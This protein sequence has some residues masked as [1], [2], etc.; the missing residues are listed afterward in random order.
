M[1]GFLKMDPCQVCGQNPQQFTLTTY[2]PLGSDSLCASCLAR[3]GLMMAKQVLPPEE[4]AQILGPMFVTPEQ[5][6]A[7]GED[8]RGR[9]KPA[10]P[11]AAETEANQGE[12]GGPPEVPAAAADK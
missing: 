4:I 9:R 2:D 7:A 1:E 3:A 11:P 10:P 12:T 8:K 6:P 5:G